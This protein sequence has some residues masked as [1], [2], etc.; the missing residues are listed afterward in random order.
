MISSQ[1]GTRARWL[2]GA[3][4]ACLLA[5][6]VAAARP[7]AS[8][9]PPTEQGR[10][11]AAYA[12]PGEL[13]DFRSK[14]NNV[15]YRLTILL[16]P[17]YD[18][19][20]GPH[21]V[22][23]LLDGNW[24]APF[25]GV[26]RHRLMLINYDIPGLIIV[27]VDYP[28]KTGRG[29]D[30]ALLKGSPWPVPSERGIA[31]FMKVMRDEVIPYIDA[32][33]RTDPKDRGIGGHSLGGFA[34]TYA[35]FHDTDLF[36]RYWL[37]SPSLPLNNAEALGYPAAYAATHKDMDVRVY[38]DV[39]EIE[40]REMR[41]LLTAVRVDTEKRGFAHLKWRQKT[42]MDQAHGA[43]P[44]FALPEALLYLYGRNVVA[45]DARR[46]SALTG[47][48][49]L[50]DG[51][52]LVV[53]SD[54]K[55]LLISGMHEP[56]TTGAPEQIALTA[57]SPESFYANFLGYALRFPV[58]QTRPSRVTFTPGGFKLAPIEGSRLGK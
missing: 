53:E 54:G 33:Y 55:R 36:R 40:A 29:E 48:Y 49:K 56:G 46:L 5:P 30:Y 11:P 17:D 9:A 37:S 22:L 10:P 19:N 51:R 26:V 14:I 23:Y 27:G 31:N 38:S 25:A 3:M 20:P 7:A 47:R 4:L 45:V 24:L 13:H 52:T 42:F 57:E 43:T 50:A 28:G 32:T 8:P 39:G 35:L 1:G 12:A 44:L 15:D 6:V 18:E 16:P 41:D 58:G 34:S 2:Q 21:P